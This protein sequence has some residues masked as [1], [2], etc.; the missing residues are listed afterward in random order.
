MRHDRSV[1]AFA[2]R[3]TRAPVMYPSR[4]ISVT[5]LALERGIRPTLRV[6]ITIAGYK[7]SKCATS[8]GM[9][10]ATGMQ[11]HF[12]EGIKDLARNAYVIL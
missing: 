9:A 10:N 1:F 2:T 3:T 4:L 11:K 12:I 6:S 5:R 8:T 7:R